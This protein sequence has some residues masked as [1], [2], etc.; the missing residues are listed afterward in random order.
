M[1]KILAITL[2]L[3]FSLSSKA[4]PI[5][6]DWLLAYYIP[7]DN[8]LAEYYHKIE[9]MMEKG[10]VSEHLAVAVQTDLPDSSGIYQTIILHDTV[11]NFRINREDSYSNQTFNEF[12]GWIKNDF[13]ANKTALIFLNHGG[14]LDETGVDKYPSERWMRID[15]MANSVRSFKEKMHG[16]LELVSFQVC[17]KANVEVAYEFE[18]TSK[19]TL[20]SQFVLGAPNY[21]YEKVFK[22]LS[23][24]QINGGLELAQSI[25][26]NDSLNMY[27]SYTCIENQHLK[28]FMDQFKLYAK[29]M[30]ASSLKRTNG[31]LHNTVYAHEEHWDFG[32]LIGAFEAKYDTTSVLND[33]KRKYN[34]LIAFIRVNPSKNIVHPF[35]GMSVLAF[36]EIGYM[37]KYTHLRFFKDVNLK[38]YRKKLLRNL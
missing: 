38:L 23:A 1:R 11:F 2:I 24:Q 3:G 31:Q 8:N 22:E 34:D 17:S 14:Q 36:N 10:V 19:Y 32:S 37:K 21:Y 35:S 20:F 6:V 26:K 29:H 7:Y 28:S 16:E 30:G 25:T 27:Y 33:L 15:S 4:A 5:K 18:N 12:L 13:R 9:S